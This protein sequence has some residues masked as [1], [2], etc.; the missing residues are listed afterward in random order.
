MKC[1]EK[2]C[3]DVC[4]KAQT[5]NYLVPSKELNFHATCIPSNP[6]LK[7]ILKTSKKVY[8]VMFFDI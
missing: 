3:Q 4:K 6:I 7:T 1:H 5:F 8:E 2:P